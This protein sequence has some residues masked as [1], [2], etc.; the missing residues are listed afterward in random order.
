MT[1]ASSG[2]RTFEIVLGLCG[3]ALAPAATAQM[4][5]VQSE[6]KISET[7]GGFGGDL[8]DDAFG[9]SLASPGDLDGDGIADLAVG[10]LGDDDGGTDQGA[11][12]VLFLDTDGTVRSEQKISETAGG[13]GGLLDP[14]D[15]FGIS[16]CSMG[17]L[18]G[19]GI[20][21]LAVG[22][23]F[24]D[25]GD[26]DQGAVWI[27]FLGTDGTVQA[28]QKISATAGG[29]GGDLDDSDYFGYA[30]GC[31]GDLD[32]DG[33][34]DLAV[35]APVDDDGG[36]DQGAVWIL[37][38]E[39][40]GTVR[41]EQKISA[42]AGGFGGHLDSS[43]LFGISVCSPGDLDGD[44]TLDLAVGA[45]LDDDGTVSQGAAWVL[46]LDTD[47]TVESE[48]KISATAGGFGGG[49]EGGDQFGRSVSALG[50]LDGDGSGDLAVGGVASGI[51]GATWVLLLNPDG[52]VRSDQKIAEMVGGFGGVLDTGDAFGVSVSALEDLDGN[53]IGDLAVGAQQDDDGGT[54]HGAVWILFLDDAD[55][56]PPTISC[57]PPL[58]VRAPK[59]EPHGATVSF[60]VSAS[61]DCD[62][63]P[64]IECN[65]PSGSFFPWGTSTV[66]CTATD[67]WGNTS[68]CAF[69]VTVRPSVRRFTGTVQ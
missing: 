10:A 61:D 11:L 7:A 34:V 64:T 15:R 1:R 35:G 60:S 44:G 69:T 12:W 21:D 38:L 65:P 56:T 26:T 43:D 20:G 30:L 55:T 63:S 18:D 24:D 33:I 57:P 28:E 19:D 42:T 48:Q 58:T 39:S 53:G 3:F 17:D 50:D 49:L 66:T 45:S 47:G 23:P 29:F 2:F 51:G 31:M 14:G 9:A 68:M 40:D 67:G 46:F 22:A 37:F 32:G 25:D 41:A 36:T 16:A 59:S 13:F 5:L 62:P 8:D 4:C 54:D 27:L 6:Q 52:T